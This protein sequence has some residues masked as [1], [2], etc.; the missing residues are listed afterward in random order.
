MRRFIAAA[1]VIT[2]FL[3]LACNLSDP[4]PA[5]MPADGG[6]CQS[7]ADCNDHGACEDGECTCD[8]EYAGDNCETCAAAHFPTEDGLCVSAENCLGKIENEMCVGESCA[9]GKVASTDGETCVDDLCFDDPCT[10][11]N[12]LAGS[13]TMTSDTEFTCECEEGWTG[14][15]CQRPASLCDPSPCVN[16]ACMEDADTFMCL[17]QERFGGELC[18]E[19]APGFDNFENMCADCAPGYY[20]QECQYSCETA[21]AQTWWNAGYN[22]RIAVLVQAPADTASPRGSLIE[23]TIP[24][25]QWIAAGALANGQDVR[26]VSVN[27][28]NWQ[29]TEI[30]RVLAVDSAWGLGD[31]RIWWASQAD[32]EAGQYALFY[33]YFGNATA[34]MPIGVP[35]DVLA[36]SRGWAK[37]VQNMS[38]LYSPNRRSLGA[39]SIHVRQLSP[40]EF[41]VAYT[42][43]SDDINA[44][45]SVL[46]TDMSDPPVTV[47]QRSWR[48]ITGT[49]NTPQSTA[50]SF[51]TMEPTLVIR[52]DVADA[53]A[54]AMIRGLSEQAQPMPG[55]FTSTRVYQRQAPVGGDPT[56]VDTCTLQMKP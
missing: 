39:T 25:D 13:C 4:R 40:G 38:T 3:P 31:T 33:I 20:G 22:Q 15:D 52:L 48:D 51:T 24:H 46:V 49:S 19:C 14:D 5:G 27:P 29:N 11:E 41:E 21:D 28:A 17:C 54:S 2:I 12:Q 9:E 35:G 45:A 44:N 10:G 43:N 36:A 7:H 8:P 50:A 37:D 32:L 30:P 47:F 53:Q 42:D 1:A 55:S 16:G 18:D 6:A 56:I 34:G 26:V 23:A